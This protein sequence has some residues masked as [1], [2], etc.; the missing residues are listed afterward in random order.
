ME[1]A[2]SKQWPARRSRLALAGTLFSLPSGCFHFYLDSF[3][4]AEAEISRER[5]SA[6]DAMGARITSKQDFAVALTKI[7]QHDSAWESVYSEL[8]DSGSTDKMKLRLPS[9]SFLDIA[10]QQFRTANRSEQIKQLESERLAHPTDSH[11]SLRERLGALGYTLQDIYDSAGN[12]RPTEPSSTLI[13]NADALERELLPDFAPK[14]QEAQ[15]IFCRRQAGFAAME[16]YALI[17]N[18]S[19]LVYVRKEGLYGMKFRGLVVSNEG[20]YFEPV[21]DLLDDPWFTPGS[22]TFQKVMKESGANFFIPR[23]DIVDVQF[24]SSPKWGMGQIPHAGKLKIRLRSGK[25]RK[26]VLLGDAYG[27]GIRRVILQL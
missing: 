13:P 18:R 3:S 10:E 24:D 11:P 14:S 4:E 25:Y 8:L 12:L 19:F 15:A 22:K 20:T 21:L 5:E 9:E 27:D 1:R 17:L 26:F 6:A 23:A 16:Y 2:R 7:I